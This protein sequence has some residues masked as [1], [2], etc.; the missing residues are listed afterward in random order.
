MAREEIEITLTVSLD[1]DYL[2]GCPRTWDDPGEEPGWELINP[3]F[4]VGKDTIIMT[5]ETWE[6]LMKVYWDSIET[7][8]IE[9]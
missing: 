1:V 9:K 4:K 2:P 5:D 6:E 3:Y 8:L 7:Q